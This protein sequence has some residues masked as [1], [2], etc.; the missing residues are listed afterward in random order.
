M[1]KPRITQTT[2]HNSAGDLPPVSRYISDTVQDR[3]TVTMANRNSFYQLVLFPVTL[4]DL[5]FC[6]GLDVK[7]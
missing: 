6:D 4:N 7:P 3:N 1:T 5:V 2:P